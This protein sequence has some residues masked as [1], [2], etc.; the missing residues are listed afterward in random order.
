[1]RFI[2]ILLALI[3]G[4]P[5]LAAEAIY[6]F[7]AFDTTI[8]PDFDEK[9]IIGETRITVTAAGGAVAS[10]DVTANALRVD[11]VQGGRITAT[12]NGLWTV[13]LDAPLRPGRMTTVTVKYSGKPARGLIFGEDVVY[14][15]YFACDWMICAQ[16]RPGDKAAFTLRLD[17]PPGLTSL[18][19]GTMSR[20]PGTRG[21]ERHVWRETRPYSSFLYGFAAGRMTSAFLPSRRIVLAVL[22][23]RGAADSARIQSM[24]ATTGEMLDFFE[25]KAGV[26]FPHARYTQLLVKGWEAQEATHFS[27]IGT[28]MIDPI[29]ANLQEDWVIAHELAH[30][31]WGN[32]VTC[33]DWSEFWLN[34][35]IVT[36]MTAAWK[37]QKHGR[38][39]YDREMDLA[40]KRLATA[41][42]AGFDKP[43]AWRGDYPSLRIRRAVQYSKGALFLDA[44]RTEIGDGAFWA[45]LKLYTQRHAGGT[46]VSADFQRAMEQA[47]QRDLSAMFKTWVTG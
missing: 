21:L 4:K 13:T 46:V 47:S 43:L 2:A 24:F 25:A 33:A 28:Q 5:S 14:T 16:D 18:G 11:A 32:L 17:L 9:T 19:P 26:P 36:F 27:I 1:V 35:G 12:Q 29:L 22:A 41:A 38:A 34:E 7:A 39:A 40:R 10:F 15:S 20:E 44:L 42:E 30:Q 3:L 31:W 23:E 45:G 8:A 6:D 37:E